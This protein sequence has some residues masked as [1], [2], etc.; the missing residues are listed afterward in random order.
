MCETCHCL[1]QE[2]DCTKRN[3]KMFAFSRDDKSQFAAS[4]FE[5]GYSNPT[6][7]SIARS[8][9]DRWY[10]DVC[11]EHCEGKIEWD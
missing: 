2:E 7:V 3:N 6:H 9:G 1:Q 8:S 5:G 4:E 11:K 10:Y